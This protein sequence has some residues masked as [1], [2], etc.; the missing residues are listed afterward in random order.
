M[1]DSP[2]GQCKSPSGRKPDPHQAF[3]E[4]DPETMSR[5]GRISRR[6]TRRRLRLVVPSLV[7][8]RDG[9][10]GQRSGPGTSRRPA[11]ARPAP[12]RHRQPAAPNASGCP[13]P[14][15]VRRSRIRACP[16]VPTDRSAPA[17]APVITPEGAGPEGPPALAPDVQVVRFQ[18]PRGLARRGPR[19][20][21]RRRFPSATATA[22]SRSA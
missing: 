3:V 5:H 13:N 8:A 12:P 22:S 9:E 11:L 17:S 6:P 14:P 4:Q 18:G 7:I 15:P 21:R 1:L 16:S 20:R 19:A 2:I 10:P